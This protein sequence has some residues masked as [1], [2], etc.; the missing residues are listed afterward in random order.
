[1]T[2]H[3]RFL[4]F[5]AVFLAAS[6]SAKQDSPPESLNA[7]VT[8]EALASPGFSGVPDRVIASNGRIVAAGYFVSSPAGAQ[9][10]IAIREPSGTWSVPADWPDVSVSAIAE[11]VQGGRTFVGTETGV[12]VVENGRTR[13]LRSMSPGVSGLHWD[14]ENREL[15]VGSSRRILVWDGSAWATHSL[16]M[17]GW[18]RSFVVRPTDRTQFAVLDATP[19]AFLR[20][21]GT[22]WSV[23]EVPITGG[24]STESIVSAVWH[25]VLRAIVIGGWFWSIDGRS[26]EGLAAWDGTSWAPLLPAPAQGSGL[27][28][29]QLRWDPLHGRLLAGARNG[30]IFEISNQRRQPLGD[31]M[32]GSA[33]GHL[34][35]FSIDPT[36]GGVIALGLLGRSG[37]LPLGRI[38]SWDGVRWLPVVGALVDEGDGL[39]IATDA[40]SDRIV[41]GGQFSAVAGVPTNGLV[42]WSAGR[43]EN[44]GNPIGP[45]GPIRAYSLIWDAARDV[46]VH[47]GSDGTIGYPEVSI[48]RGGSWSPLPKPSGAMRLR[49]IDL[50]QATGDIFFIADQRRVFALRAGVWRL[51]AETS[52]DLHVGAWDAARR[53]LVFASFRPGSA[54][55]HDILALD[56]AAQWTSL[57]AVTKAGSVGTYNMIEDIDIHPVSGAIAIAGT[58]DAVSGVSATNIATLEA[59]AWRA[60]GAGT[61]GP[62]LNVEWSAKT[63]A[64]AASGHFSN[65]GS[66]SVTGGFGIWAGGTWTHPVL[67]HR[68][69]IDGMAAD[70]RSGGFV[71]A[72]QLAVVGQ[73]AASVARIAVSV[74]TIVPPPNLRIEDSVAFEGQ[75]GESSVAVRITL[76]APAPSGGVRFDWRTEDG[77]ATA[78]QDYVA[79]TGSI[80]IP[81][82]AS[83]TTVAIRIRGDELLEPD[84]TFGV[85]LS[86]VTGAVV[87][88]TS[89][90]V[91]I[92]ND[93]SAPIPPL[94]ARPDRFDV[95]A[96]GQSYTIDVLANDLFDV[97]RLRGGVIEITVSPS[98]G[99]A[100]IW[101]PT[102]GD[103]DA[104]NDRIGVVVPSPM[105]SPMR[106]RY[107]ICEA[108]GRCSEA[109]LEIAVRQAL[110]V[111]SVRR[112][113]PESG[114]RDV[115]ATSVGGFDDGFF[116]AFGLFAPHRTDTTV[117]ADPVG[118]GPWQD[119]TH[120]L[121]V[122]TLHSGQREARWRTFVD[123][124]TA[125]SDGGVDVHVGRDVNGDGRAQVSERLC[126]S[127]ASTSI[128]R[129]PVRCELSLVAAAGSSTSYW[130]LLH[131]RGRAGPPLAATV[132]AFDVPLDQPSAQRTLRATGP[133]VLPE[134]GSANVRLSWDLGSVAPEE[135][136]GGWVR[137]SA[138]DGALEQWWPVRVEGAP[139]PMPTTAWG[140]GFNPTVVLKAGIG[141]S[142]QF[143]IDVPAGLNTAAVTI[144]G[145]RPFTATLREDVPL[146]SLPGVPTFPSAQPAVPVVQSAASVANRVTLSVIRPSGTRYWVEVRNAD[147]SALRISSRV[148]FTGGTTGLKPGAFFNPARSG[149]GLFLYP[150]GDV[151]AGL[152]YTY[153]QDGTPTWYYLQGARP[154]A[155]GVWRGTLHRSVWLRDR[156]RL[157]P[158][159]EAIVTPDAGRGAVFTYSLDGEWGS[160]KLEHFGSGC[161]A[162][163]QN[164]ID[165][166][167]HWFDPR[168]AGTGYSAQFFARYEFFA[169][170]L[171]DGS[172]QPRFLLAESDGAGAP[173][174]SIPLVQLRGFCPLC[175]RNGAPAR[176]DVGTLVRTVEGAGLRTF[177]HSYSF[178]SPV[179]GTGT[180]TDN[181]V[182][183]GS[184]QGCE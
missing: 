21:S 15:L 6:L 107:R 92:R 70:E 62:V 126:S 12:Y 2:K 79:G 88:R 140:A 53:R 98:T 13:L 168:R 146:A 109:D 30:G 136:R 108:G 82:G 10:G 74:P 81:A 97:S 57:G 151:L 122:R 183:L 162:I 5:A 172:G 26:A 23:V 46:L 67:T 48:R 130:I 72:G 138:R 65:A 175:V 145:D 75:A 165:A 35:D 157:T 33:A 27:I 20:R 120:R 131:Q 43:W 129:Y 69:W 42:N 38:A 17:S 117:P 149:H 18:V 3:G 113:A 50:D 58:F 110:S 101:S 60:L 102:P 132:E 154:E 28:W 166:S 105:T 78:G 153:K 85:R 152:W 56:S 51:L 121:I 99:R 73:P 173:Q 178:A 142:R 100:F 95:P 8:W 29:A 177:G 90:T 127:I 25:P 83:E 89:A 9:A 116:E 174:R 167:G 61:N 112:D 163:G 45:S 49:P 63:A 47:E 161:P 125:P 14:A 93:D 169:A 137:L 124:R 91:T 180:F 179:T 54:G 1:M 114:W 86:A 66:Q 59:G 19:S 133:S 134:G 182:P 37:D 84:E 55:V 104:T 135:S 164:V 16:S 41:V 123:V 44:V 144:D 32:G 128:D 22:T 76:D 115:E 96:A 87:Q 71:L 184:T 106:I 143:V 176:T 147:G 118:D 31:L 4:A 24:P 119:G 40:G 111:P 141:Q 171:Y 170:F 103:G 158:V 159:G 36:T 77:T 156:N 160:E 94:A 80:A 68:G 52:R 7:T 11:D 150:A 64:I 155:H 148:Q 34:L 139:G 181:V 39:A